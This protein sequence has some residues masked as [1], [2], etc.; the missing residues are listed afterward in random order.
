MSERIKDNNRIVNNTL[1]LYI[2]MFLIMAVTL[3]TS[4]VVLDKLGVDDYGIYHSV[5]GVVAMLAFLNNTLSTGTSRF[6]TFELGKGS[7]NT[8][9]ETFNTVFYAHLLL[10]IIVVIFFETIG[11]WFIKNKLIIPIDE[12]SLLSLYVK[13]PITLEL[14]L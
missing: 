7:R 6:L 12:I 9:S 11:I 10:A 4:R 3:Y 14:Y 1:F 13:K 8:L 2:R 5:S